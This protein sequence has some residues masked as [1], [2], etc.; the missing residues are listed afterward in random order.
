MRRVIADTGFF[1]ALGRRADPCHPRATRFADGFE[2]ELITTSPIIVESCHF[3]HVEWRL[4]LLRVIE[5]G[6][7]KVAEVPVS[8]Y[9]ELAATIRKYANCD[10]DFADASLVWL[11]EHTGLRQILTLDVRDFSVLR[12]KNGKRFELVDWS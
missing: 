5:E 11:A 12:F 3:L 4:S 1:V 2:G 8:S 6:R 7:I 10:I 9:P